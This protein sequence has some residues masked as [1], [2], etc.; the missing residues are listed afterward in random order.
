MSL[1]IVKMLWE[2]C[3]LIALW[4]SATSVFNFYDYTIFL[5]LVTTFLFRF[6]ELYG[7]FSIHKRNISRSTTLN[8]FFLSY[9][10]ASIFFSFYAKHCTV[11]STIKL[12]TICGHTTKC[13]ERWN[14]FSCRR[15]ATCVS[16]N[17]LT[18]HFPLF[19][20]DSPGMLNDCQIETALTSCKIFAKKPNTS[21]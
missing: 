4:S 7:R 11:L 17:K 16:V 1:T 20:T 10:Y 8:N 19:A 3:S 18:R 12:I 9:F 5:L 2:F 14:Y 15:L 6:N 13:N 21:R